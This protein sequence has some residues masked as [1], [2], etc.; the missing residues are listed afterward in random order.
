MS[1][2]LWRLLC[3]P[4]IALFVGVCGVL[5]LSVE[6]AEAQQ[7]TT[8]AGRA[9]TVVG[10][11]GNDILRGTNG[12]DVFVAFGGD[13]IVYG[14]G[15]N[16]VICGGHGDDQ[17]YG[18]DGADRIYA[19]NGADLVVGGR[20]ADLV[21]GGRGADELHGNNGRD[22]LRGGP[23]KDELRGGSQRDSLQGGRHLDTLLGGTE[24]DECYSPNDLLSGCERGGGALSTAA[25]A[26]QSVTGHYQ[27]EMLRL[28]NVERA[29]YGLP[30]ITRDSSLDTYA[31][32]W[33][34]TMSEQ[35]LPLDRIRHHSPAFTGSSIS[36]RDLPSTEPW[37]HAFE[38]VGRTT[39][40]STE[41]V[42]AV[43]NRLFYATGGNGF[44]T[45]PGH[46]CNILETAVDEVGLGAH[47]DSAGALW[48]VQVFWGHDSPTPAPLATCSGTVQR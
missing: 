2:S 6:G 16:D 38:N 24:L 7:R 21:H 42:A 4:A 30:A 11:N 26:T 33:A 29:E 23:G 41:S 47:V 27:A 36:F 3:L 37:T 25:L 18:G 8:C 34:V 15:G 39:I 1:E 45:S 35:P 5:L 14:L 43:V 9:A 48:V 28:I 40:R 17:L 13:D 20:G 19:F 32:A 12:D 46:H 44:T 22:T 31:Q 10:T